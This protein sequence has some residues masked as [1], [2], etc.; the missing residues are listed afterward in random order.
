MLEFQLDLTDLVTFA[1]WRAEQS[2]EYRQ[3]LPRQRLIA[4]WVA[5]VGGYLAVSVLW[6]I[7]A[8]VLRGWVGA[9]L[10]EL[11]ALGLGLGAGLWEWR[12]GRLAGYLTQRRYRRW[13]KAALAR[14]GPN[15]EL[16]MDD[17][18]LRVQVGR[19]TELVNWSDIDQLVEVGQRVFVLTGDGAA[20]IIPV[21]VPGASAFV[22]DLRQH[23]HSGRLKGPAAP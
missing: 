12:H 15:R 17:S 7:P 11:V 14:T 20:H 18:G 19:R 16:R 8:L 13:G 5:G 10:G 3:R 6:T 21:Q 23:L 22:S 2:G 1:A 9:G 4:A